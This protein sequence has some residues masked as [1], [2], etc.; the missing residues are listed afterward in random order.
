M[1]DLLGVRIIF[2]SKGIE[3]AV[4]T[5]QFDN[6]INFNTHKNHIQGNIKIRLFASG[7]ETEGTISGVGEVLNANVHKLKL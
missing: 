3:L 6:K 2:P 5:C 7:V 4:M 1:I